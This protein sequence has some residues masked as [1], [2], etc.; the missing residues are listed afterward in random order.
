MIAIVTEIESVAPL[1]IVTFD[2]QGFT[3]KM[4]S[5]E[6]QNVITVGQKVLLG[7]KP[8]AVGVVKNLD[9]ESSFS[10]QIKSKVLEVKHGELLS[11]ITVEIVNVTLESIMIK[12]SAEALNLFKGEEVLVLIG[13]SDLSIIEVLDV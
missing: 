3:L 8:T 6:I 2:F 13:A 11:S 4:M 10:N 1:N 5:L 9:T 12:K 7:V